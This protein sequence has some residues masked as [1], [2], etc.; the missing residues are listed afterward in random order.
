MDR[1]RAEVIRAAPF[2]MAPARSRRIWPA[3]ALAVALMA[4]GRAAPPSPQPT[5][6]APQSE[7]AASPAP[8]STVAATSP[9]ASAEVIFTD[10]HILTMDPSLPA[11]QALAVAGDTILAVGSNDEV[12]RF[13][14]AATVVIDLDGA[15]MTPGFIDAHQHRIGNRGNIGIDNP[16]DVIEPA[17]EQ[18]WTSIDELYVDQGRLNELIDLD[19]AGVL[20]LRVDAYLPVMENSAEGRM[21]GDYYQAYTPGEM[22]SPHVRVAGLKI[23]T[24]F[25]NA[26]I[27]LWQPETL[28][29]FI[30]ARLQEGWPLAI[31]TVSTRSLEIILQAIEGAQAAVPDIPDRRIRL[32]HML[33]ATPDQIARLQRLGLVPVINLNNPG[34]LVGEPDID[35]LIE[36]EPDGSYTPWR[37]LAQAGV[38]F[39]NASGFPS[40]YVDEPTGAPFGSPMHLIYQAVTRVGNLGRQPYPWLLDQ[41]ITAEQAMRAL[42]IDGAFAGFQDDVKGS[43]SPGKLADLVVLSQDPLAVPADQVNHIEVWMTMIGGRVEWCAPGHESLCPGQAPPPSEA[44]DPFLGDWAANDPTDGSPMSLRVTRQDGAYNVTLTDELATA[45]GLDASGKP[46][47]SAEVDATGQVDGNVLRTTVTSLRCLSEPPTSR[48]LSLTIDYTYQ[49]DSDTLLDNSQGAIWHRP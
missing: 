16:V 5:A 33:F 41:A 31:K 18:G 10:G 42:T 9:T 11:A 29:A 26:T 47:V 15:T 25:D 13:E 37:N 30:E 24:D 1:D 39:A 27:L 8:D 14:G 46:T 22:V 44:Q 43:L 45:C 2:T 34:Q 7:S 4:C 28:Q 32:E 40:F 20:R 23:F 36:R 48:A 19:R 21:L 49:A 38:R 35:Q 12:T 17:I 6:A 3:V